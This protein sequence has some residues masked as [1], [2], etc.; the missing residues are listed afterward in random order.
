LRFKQLPEVTNRCSTKPKPLALFR[1]DFLTLLNRFPS[2]ASNWQ[3]VGSRQY[4]R[5]IDRKQTLKI[6]HLPAKHET[7]LQ[8]PVKLSL[9]RKLCVGSE[10]RSER[11]LLNKGFRKKGLDVT[12]ERVRD[13]IQFKARHRA[14]TRLDLPYSDP[15]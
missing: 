11:I 5:A 15:A 2:R 6:R 7:V 4:L 10:K 9:F 3:L 1:S 14:S 13:P 8:C 12:T